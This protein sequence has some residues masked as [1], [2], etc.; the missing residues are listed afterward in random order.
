MTLLRSRHEAFGHPGIEPRWTRGGKQ[1]VGTAYSRASRVWY[2]CAAGVLTEVYFPTIDKP[3]IRDLQFLVTDGDSFFH[4][5][6]RDT[7]Y[8]IS[9]T[10][11]TSLGVKLI[12]EDRA[13]RYRIVKRIVSN[14]AEPV[15]LIR[16]RFEVADASLAAK[17]RLFVLIA[18]H[19]DGG[20]GG[21][22]ANLAE[23]DGRVVLTAHRNAAWLAC[24]ATLPFAKASCGFVGRSDGWTDLNAHRDLTWEF[25]AAENGN[26]AL[27][28]ELDISQSNEFTLGLAFG[29]HLHDAATSLFHSLG[30]PFEEHETQFKAQWKRAHGKALPLEP[31]SSDGGKLYRCSHAVLLA[32][33]DKNYPGAMI[34]S[35]SIPWG[36]AKG[37]EDL[38]GY[39]LVWPRD[40]V[41]TTTALLASGN[42]AT[43]LRA[44]IYLAV[45]QR[46]DG[47]FYQ[48][49]WLD[50]EPYWQGVQLDEVAFPI[51]LAW[52]LREQQ[53]LADYDPY[54]MVRS[55]A[56][57]LVK[58]GPATPQERWEENSGYSPSTLAVNIAALVCAAAFARER[59]ESATANYLLDYA[60]FLECHVEPWTV[61]DRGTLLTDV[62]RHYIRI[63]PVDP[64]DPR[65][66][67]NPND[68]TI[69]I[70]NGPRGKHYAFPANRI[71]DAGFLE[72]VRYGVRAPGDPL[73]ED[74]LR[75]VDAQLKVDTPAGPVWRRYNHDGYGEDDEGRPFQGSGVGRGWPLL[76]GERGHYELAAGRDV[77]PFIRTLEGFA[78]GCGLLPEQVWDRPDIAEKFLFFGQ[79]T[80]AAMPL[81]WAHAE[82]VKLLRSATDGCVFDRVQ[83]VADRYL[84]TRRACRKL[85]VWKFNRQVGTLRAGFTLRIQAVAPFTLKW[86]RGEWDRASETEAAPTSLGVHFVDID[87]TEASSAPIRFTFFW[88]GGGR[89]EGRDFRV[90]VV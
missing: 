11:K 54:P 44:L 71:V 83:T 50:G 59:G 74:S 37:D 33:E 12:N 29:D 64:A 55:A 5:E 75:V 6:R 65:P 2:T 85:E 77:A 70:K 18:P 20:G 45:A 90:E 23:V 84:G 80:G 27:I 61:T 86:T 22:T 46:A 10:S 9:R 26:V 66:D 41:N 72:L 35:L 57:F 4:D 79:P 40:M 8:T 7:D 62:P 48:N 51:L 1:A 58:H 31:A 82:Y 78:S 68:G 69:V 81:C 43:P 32:H 56:A 13:G 42:T 16:T 14:P 76:T 52:K 38:G 30:T 73:I 36:D 28:G 88:P 63:H 17:L 15:L 34:A 89:W 47:G 53:A 87:V 24:G 3:Q 67:E 19:L 39:H 21:N 25:D 49:F 60:D